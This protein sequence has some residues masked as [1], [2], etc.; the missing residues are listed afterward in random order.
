MPSRHYCTIPFS[1]NALKKIRK[2]KEVIC[3]KVNTVIEG[4]GR[5]VARK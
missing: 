3:V 1:G 2:A 5:P 4:T